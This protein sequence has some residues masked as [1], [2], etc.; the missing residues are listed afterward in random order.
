MAEESDAVAVWDGDFDFSSFDDV[1]LDTDDADTPGAPFIPPWDA[2]EA[3]PEGMS[4]GDPRDDAD[5]AGFG[6]Y[7]VRPPSVQM[8][9][10]F[11][12]VSIYTNFNPSGNQE[13]EQFRV[14]TDPFDP[15]TMDFNAPAVPA[16]IYELRIRGMDMLNLNTLFFPGTAVCINQSGLL[17]EVLK[18]FR[19]GDTVFGD[20]NGNGVQDVGEQ[21]IMGVEVELLG[22]ASGLV[23]KTLTD[24][25]GSYDFEVD[26]GTFSVQVAER[27]FL[28][29]G[30]LVDRLPTVGNLLTAEILDDNVLTYDFGYTAIA[31]PPAVEI[32][33]LSG[34]GGLVLAGLLSLLAF[35]RL[36]RI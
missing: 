7:I 8:D 22:E 21:G 1:D 30:A 17:C 35:H 13:W 18:S 12:D 19:L 25:M 29:G 36:R 27:N 11:P 14:S 15:T 32:P 3:Q 24:A 6:I 10:V 9:L 20:R 33:T 31:T 23:S 4:L 5:E 28:P 2:G 34:W 26:A 16:G